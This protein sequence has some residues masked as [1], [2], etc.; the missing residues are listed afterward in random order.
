MSTVKLKSNDGQ[1]FEVPIS[2]AEM[3][4]TVA[5]I[6]EDVDTL[7]FA[8]HLHEVSGT[9]L[10]KVL[11]YCDY[12]SE[13]GKSEQEIKAWDDLYTDVDTST[14]F[15]LILAAN[16]LDNRPLIELTC[17]KVADMAKVKKHLGEKVFMSLIKINMGDID[18]YLNPEEKKDCIVED[19]G[20]RS[21]KI[22]KR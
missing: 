22:V 16:Y 18:A 10:A 15:N 4:G 13:G 5:A 19:R 9:I 14:L 7:D 8:I 6:L 1:V 20:P 17:K 3:N 12:H 2:S 11:E 21:V